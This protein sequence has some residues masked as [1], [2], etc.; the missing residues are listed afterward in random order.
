MILFPATKQ[1]SFLAESLRVLKRSAL[2]LE[3]IQNPQTARADKSVKDIDTALPFLRQIRGVR[4]AA[5]H[6][7]MHPDTA[8]Q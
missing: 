4:L 1:F 8:M 3:Y 5:D 7:P 2:I 6:K